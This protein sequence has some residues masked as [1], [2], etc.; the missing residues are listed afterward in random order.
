MPRNT[1]KFALRMA[2]ET[3][4]LVKEWFPKDNCQTQNEYIEKAIRFYTGYLSGQD[5]T[6]FLP[7]ALVAALRGVVQNSESRTARLLFKLAVEVAMMSKVLA[8]GLEID[9]KELERIRG[10][11]VQEVKK[12]NGSI[13]FKDAVEQVR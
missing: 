8:L 12:T 13:S 11:C 3:Q 6:A 4:Q 7:V 2:P 1:I 9:P 10:Q 5:A